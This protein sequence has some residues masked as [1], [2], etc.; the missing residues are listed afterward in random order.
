MNAMH[1]TLAALAMVGAAAMAEAQVT[2]KKAL[3]GATAL[4]GSAS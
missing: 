1:R 3:A 4:A 2:T